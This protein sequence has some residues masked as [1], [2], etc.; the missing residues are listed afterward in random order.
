[1]TAGKKVYRVELTQRAL[2]DLLEI[3]QHSIT[4]WGRKVASKYLDEIEAALDRLQTAPEI[5]QLDPEFAPGVYF[6]RVKKHFLVC[7]LT[8]DTV[9]VLTLI[10]TSMDLP[11]RLLELEPRLIAEIQMIRSSRPG[12]SARSGGSPFLR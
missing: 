2:L 5:L 11:A 4:E 7:D 6:Y 9:I 10:H 1:M 12:S 3:E 8:G